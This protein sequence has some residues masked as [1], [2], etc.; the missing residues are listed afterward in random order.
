MRER[1]PWFFSHYISAVDAIKEFI[2]PDNLSFDG[3]EVAD[4]GCGDGII[5]LGIANRLKPKKLIGY[6]INPVNEEKLQIKSSAL[7]GNQELPKNLEFR[8]CGERDIPA[9]D[10]SFDWVISWSAFEHITD[11]VAVL[12]EI[13]RV[14]RPEGV[15][16]IQ[17]FPFYHS[18]WGSHLEEWFSAPYVQHRLSPEQI[19]Q[20]LYNNPAPN[21]SE[22]SESMF[23]AFRTLNK[24]TLDDLHLYLQESGFLVRKAELITDAQHIPEESLKFPLSA[25]LVGGVSLLATPS[26]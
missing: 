23:E 24:I 20:H 5:D 18:A 12:G 10:N 15:L 17:L 19:Q 6:D 14:L 25:L 21:K 1:D 7:I 4:I 22:H 9:D 2:S 11:P 3:A 8:R 16:F 13:H 26:P